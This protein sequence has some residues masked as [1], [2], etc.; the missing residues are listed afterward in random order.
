MRWEKFR[1]SDWFATG[2][3]YG[4]D[5]Q[6]AESREQ[7]NDSLINTFAV[8]FLIGAAGYTFAAY[9]LG[10][11]TASYLGGNSADSL[12]AVDVGL[13]GSIVV[14]GKIDTALIPVVYMATGATTGAVVRLAANGRSILSVTRLGRIV[15]DMEIGAAVVSRPRQHKDGRLLRGVGDGAG[16]DTGNAPR[17]NH[18]CATVSGFVSKW[19]HIRPGRGLYSNDPSFD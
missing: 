14:A 9:S 8:I 4:A 1:G 13:D 10:P 18:A 6:R 12:N 16:A 5:K 7:G 17:A 3:I 19:G 2:H 15:T 11:L